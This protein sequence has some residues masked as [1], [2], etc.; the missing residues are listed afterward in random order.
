MPRAEY[1][2]LALSEHYDSV[3][4]TGK[5]ILTHFRATRL[6]RIGI[7]RRVTVTRRLCCLNRIVLLFPG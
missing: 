2:L 7:P 6:H 5:E 3:L 4:A 1:L